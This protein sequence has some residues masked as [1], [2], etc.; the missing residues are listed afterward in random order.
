MEGVLMLI[1]KFHTELVNESFKINQQ[2]ENQKK[3]KIN[4]ESL[5][6]LTT[7]EN[8]FNKFTEINI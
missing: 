3:E 7:V 5:V 8:N 2:K 4:P 6:D 1:F